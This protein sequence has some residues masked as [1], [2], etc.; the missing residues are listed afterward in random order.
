MNCPIF[1]KGIKEIFVFYIY[2][3]VKKKKKK[4]LVILPL[5]TLF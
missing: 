1:F 4:S 2:V 5:I 3:Y